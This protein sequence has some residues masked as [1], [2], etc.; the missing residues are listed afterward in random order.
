MSSEGVAHT[1]G[2][3]G[4]VVILLLLFALRHFSAKLIARM[5]VALLSYP[6]GHPRGGGSKYI[7]PFCND[8]SQ[9]SGMCHVIRPRPYT[10]FLQPL[11]QDRD[12]FTV[13]A[14]PSTAENS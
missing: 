13:C 12:R 14:Y 4:S 9:L 7:L 1:V 2:R 5:V 11:S 10:R 3:Y 8:P 6:C